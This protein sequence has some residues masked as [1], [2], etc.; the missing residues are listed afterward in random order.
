MTATLTD[1]YVFAVARSLPEA[2]RDDVERELR[3]TIADDVDARV[4]AGTA[5]ADAERAALTELGDPARLVAG[6][7]DRPLHLIGPRYYLAWVRLLRLLLIVVLPIVAATSVM[8]HLIG[9][10]PPGGIFGATIGLLIT[11]A[12]HL[13]F[14]TA[15]V[16]WLME[17]SDQRTM[18]D[19]W[20]L[21]TLP[22]PPVKGAPPFSDMV[23]SVAFLVVAAVAIVGQ[24]F[25]SGFSDENGEVIP[26]LAPQ[27]W[28]WGIPILLAIIAAEIG[29]AVWLWK[30]ARWTVAHVIVNIV[31]ALGA[32]A[33]VL[34]LVTG[35]GLYS[36]EWFAQFGADDEIDPRHIANVITAVAAVGIALWDSVDGVVKF[37]R[38]KP[39][40]R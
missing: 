30:S 38:Q 26:I 32:A 7:L 22:T 37:L 10:T 8:G 6:Y 4:D 21:D 13:A 20:T 16:F 35:P 29:F 9:G 34:A 3:A 11:L 17:R 14:W 23:A 5:P 15:F 19:T 39:G 25:W 28:A 18:V 33:L 36:P 31:L 2:R 1:R 24:Q 40:R 27:L 12:V